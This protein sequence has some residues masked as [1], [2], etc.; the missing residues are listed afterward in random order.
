MSTYFYT[1]VNMIQ[2]VHRSNTLTSHLLF[3]YFPNFWSFGW[4]ENRIG[5]NNIIP[6]T[7]ASWRR[8]LIANFSNND[9]RPGA[10]SPYDEMR[11]PSLRPL[12]N[13]WKEIESNK[14]IYFLIKITLGKLPSLASLLPVRP[15]L[16]RSVVF[17]MCVSMLVKIYCTRLKLLVIFNLNFG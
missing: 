8:A 17:Q 10:D 1:G 9:L 15:C 3:H 4:F 7:H 11:K 13:I 6:W 12:Q 5:Q 14:N 2:F 16:R